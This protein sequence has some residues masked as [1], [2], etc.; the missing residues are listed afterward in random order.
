M[1][2]AQLHSNYKSNYMYYVYIKI[3]NIKQSLNYVQNL[4]KL[5]VKINPKYG[6]K[7]LELRIRFYQIYAKKLISLSKLDPNSQP[8]SSSVFIL[9]PLFQ[10]KIHNKLN[11]IVHQFE[12]FGPFTRLGIC[13]VYQTPKQNVSLVFSHYY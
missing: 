2:N 8:T 11:S 1:H 7:I 13:N 5:G 6:S 4:Q 12:A 9:S 3:L 10:W